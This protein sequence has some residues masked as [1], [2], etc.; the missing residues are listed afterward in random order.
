MIH[1]IE[2]LSFP[3]N[4]GMMNPPGMQETQVLSL[5]WEDPLEKEMATLS[6]LLAQKTPWKEE[7]G[8]L[9]SMRSQRFGHNLLTKQQ[10]IKLLF[11]GFFVASYILFHSECLACLTL[12]TPL[13]LSSLWACVR[14]HIWLSASPWTVACQALILQARILE[15]VAI[16]FSRGSSQ[17]RKW[18][19]GSCVSC[20]GRQVL[21]QLSHQ[22]ESQTPGFCLTHSES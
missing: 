20:I 3:G 2:L 10:H 22:D 16:S 13:T 17:P 18:N 7:P 11:V 1:F 14:S 21:Y 19:H 15:W 8:G 6:S 4:S 12:V 9:Q 5:G